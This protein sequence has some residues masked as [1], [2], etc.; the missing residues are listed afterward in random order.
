MASKKSRI[1]KAVK[2]SKMDSLKAYRSPEPFL[3]FRVSQ[4]T[5][6]WAI[7]LLALITAEITILATQYDVVQLIRD[8][9]LLLLL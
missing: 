2:Y 3:T 4:Q 5:Y 7:I 1:R 6:Y 8:I 9:R